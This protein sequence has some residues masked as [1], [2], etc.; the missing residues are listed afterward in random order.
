MLSCIKNCASGRQC[1]NV[2]TQSVGKSFFVD[3]ILLPNETGAR[4]PEIRR[5]DGVQMKTVRRGYSSANA[6]TMQWDSNIL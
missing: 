2:S 5:A 6:E 1:L 3:K 4:M